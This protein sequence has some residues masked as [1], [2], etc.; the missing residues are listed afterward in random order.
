LNEKA[1]ILERVQGIPISFIAPGPPAAYNARDRVQENTLKHNF[2]A[3][4]AVAAGEAGVIVLAEERNSQKSI[5]QK[6]HRV[7]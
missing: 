1:P 7:L 4:S 6:N 2:A 5:I 3:G